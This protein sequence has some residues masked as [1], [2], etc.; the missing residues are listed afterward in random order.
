MATRSVERGLHGHHDALVLL[1]VNERA[2]RP[3][4][5]LAA[6]G[7]TDHLDREVGRALERR[8]AAQL[9]DLGTA[10][11]HVLLHLLPL[12]DGELRRT[13]NL[14]QRLAGNLH[15]AAEHGHLLAVAAIGGAT[16]DLV[17]HHAELLG[18]RTLQTR[19][20]ERRERR[21]LRRFQT[22][23][24]QRHQTRQVGRV[25]DN[26]HVLHIGAIGLDVLTQLLCD[27]AVAFEQILARHAGLA[28]CAARRD[29]ILRVGESLLHVGRRRDVHAVETA[30]AHLLGHTLRRKDVVQAEIGGQ[31]HHQGGLRHV[32]ADHAGSADDRQ[33][34]VCQK[35]HSYNI[36]VSELTVIA[37][38]K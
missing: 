32:R 5:R 26:H 3:A 38:Q 2:G 16:R 25:E 4:E 9:D 7:R 19:R 22:G 24:E 23:V 10:L 11:C 18:Q 33:F 15:G 27:L 21:H 12:L 31:T 8:T 14:A 29:D 30:L 28:R 37:P 34:F 20:V 36:I 6:H 1:V 13:D 35:S 17:L